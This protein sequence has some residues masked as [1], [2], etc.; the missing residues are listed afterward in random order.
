MYDDE[1][2]RICPIHGTPL[3]LNYIA[4]GKWEVLCQNPNCTYVRE[5]TQEEADSL[6]Q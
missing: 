3:D 2:E 5:L 4:D 6:D 1:I